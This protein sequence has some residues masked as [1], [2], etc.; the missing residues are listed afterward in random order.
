VSKWPEVSYSSWSDCCN[1]LHALAQLLGKTAAALAP[2]QPQLQHAALRLSSR[3]IATQP[4]PTRNGNGTLTI[5][6][7]LLAHWAEIQHSGGEKWRIGLEGRTVAEVTNAVLDTARRLGGEIV[8]NTAPQEVPWTV[9]L[10][11]DEEHHH[12][13]PEQ[14]ERYFQAAT[15]A[16]LA[17]A[18]YAA[19]FRGRQTPV[20]LWW[21][22]FDLSVNLF[23]GADAQPPASDF[24]PRNSMDCQEIVV[25]WWPGDPNY[26]KAAFYAYAHPA[27]DGYESTTIEP[28]V[29]RW[30]PRLGEFILDWSDVIHSHSPQA[31]AL[32]FAR[33]VFHEVSSACAWP[34]AL[35]ATMAGNPPPIR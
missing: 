5:T 15:H 29:A 16:A 24:I 11:E 30:E 1:T 22:S 8:I 12:Y 20:N 25:G 9:S 2:P 3:G 7:D 32:Q 33:S 18:E 27:P 28:P 6:L 26:P 21:G 10:D 4:L 13:S 23:S 19:P 31:L 14:A 17:L 35:V 34:P